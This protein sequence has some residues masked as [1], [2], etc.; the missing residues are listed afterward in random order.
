MSA[1]DER[2]LDA[3]GTAEQNV[4]RDA[5]HEYAVN[6]PAI[7]ILPSSSGVAV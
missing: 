6:P 2:R 1:C 5:K 4:P 7:N 3:A